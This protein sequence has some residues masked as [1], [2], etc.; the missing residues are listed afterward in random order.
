LIYSLSALNSNIS[1]NE[2]ASQV[3]T[4]EG[5]TIATT[6]LDA[7]SQN[8]DNPR[9]ESAWVWSQYSVML[10]E[11]SWRPKGKNNDVIDRLISCVRCNKWT[12][13]DSIRKGST[14][15]MLRHLATEHKIYPPN[16][17][18]SSQSTPSVASLFLQ[19]SNKDAMKTFEKNFD[20]VDCC[21][22]YG[23]FIN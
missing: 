19:Q 23:L 14:S 13:K 18:S 21:R 3:I 20:S 6:T 10:L 22:R 2:S 17:S 5:P 9:A 8:Q 15:N 1:P 12:V 4:T 11:S 16:L 7:T